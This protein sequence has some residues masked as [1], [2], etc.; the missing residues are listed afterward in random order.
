MHFMVS[1]IHG[2]PCMTAAMF[3]ALEA[4]PPPPPFTPAGG[5]LLEALSTR[6][7][8]FRPLDILRCNNMLTLHSRHARVVRLEDG[9]VGVCAAIKVD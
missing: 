4:L 7:S 2:V 5:A 6:G 3:Q 1:P 9:G 8:S